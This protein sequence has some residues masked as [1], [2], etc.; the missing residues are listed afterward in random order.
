M[1]LHM[2]SEQ[3]EQLA[4]WGREAGVMLRER[5]TNLRATGSALSWDNHRWTRFRTAMYVLQEQLQDLVEAFQSPANPSTQTY[6]GLIHR[7]GDQHPTSYKWS[8]VQQ[9]AL[10][11]QTMKKLEDLI[12]L[13]QQFNVD[14]QDDKAPHPRTELQIRGRLSG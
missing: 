6:L 3:I 13:W 10:A 2:S 5:F 7:K 9:R 14:F 8:K 12:H 4:E 11:E 1:N